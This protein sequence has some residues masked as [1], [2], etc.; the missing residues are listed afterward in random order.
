MAL[1]PSRTGWVRTHGYF[2]AR[3]PKSLDRDALRARADTLVNSGLI[4]RDDAGSATVYTILPGKHA[5][6][7]YYRN[8]I[9]HHFLDKTIIELALFKVQE[10]SDEEANLQFWAETERLRDLFKFEFF[11][12]PREEFRAGLVAELERIDPR[13]RERIAGDRQQARR[14]SRRLQPFIGHAVL[15]PYVE[16]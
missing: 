5:M 2:G 3:P 10:G 16:S 14:L 13:W 15:L 4:L 11:Y 9:I 8:T 1:I 12:P 7:S 6:A